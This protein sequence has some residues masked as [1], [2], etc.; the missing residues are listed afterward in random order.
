MDQAL[1]E[2]WLNADYN[3][4][5][6]AQLPEAW[7]RYKLPIMGEIGDLFDKTPKEAI[8]KI[9]LEERVFETW[10][11]GRT[12]LIGDAAHKVCYRCT[13]AMLEGGSSESHFE[14]HD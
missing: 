3:T 1:Y 12:V 5:N 7:R 13:S 2:D 14:I 6:I 9:V 11:H 10:K 4:F 8:S